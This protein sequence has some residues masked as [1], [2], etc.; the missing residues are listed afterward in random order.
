M[1]SLAHMKTPS[2]IAQAGDA[3][4]T[5]SRVKDAWRIG[6]KDAF[7]VSLLSPDGLNTEID[8]VAE[9]LAANVKVLLS[10][11]NENP[12][13]RHS[14]ILGSHSLTRVYSQTDVLSVSRQRFHRPA[15]TSATDATRD[16]FSCHFSVGGEEPSPEHLAWGQR[17][18]AHIPGTRNVNMLPESQLEPQEVM[19]LDGG[20][21]EDQIDRTQ[22]SASML[23]TVLR[24]LRLLQRDVSTLVARAS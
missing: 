17:I 15:F 18:E 24:N 2:Q 6:V 23:K 20:E 11:T 1:L 12:T 5:A 13:L 22:C 7:R 8:D 19:L 4:P 14:P 9:S 3:L 21:C 16:W 10:R